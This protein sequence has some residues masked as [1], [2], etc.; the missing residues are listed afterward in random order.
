MHLSVSAVDQTK[1]ELED[2]LDIA[3]LHLESLQQSDSDSTELAGAIGMVDELESRCCAASLLRKDRTAVAASC[4]LDAYFA[5]S[6][7]DDYKCPKCTAVGSTTLSGSSER[8]MSSSE[9]IVGG[10]IADRL[11]N[12]PACLVIGQLHTTAVSLLRQFG[13]IRTKY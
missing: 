9:L 7:L 11:S 12:L 2:L 13:A 3:R 6:T 8:V 1:E 5:E 4:C 10:W